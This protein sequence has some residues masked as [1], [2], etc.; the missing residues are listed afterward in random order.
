MD[1]VVAHKTKGWRGSE[2]LWLEK[3]YDMLIGSGVEAVKIMPLAKALG[4]SRTSFYWHF[5]DRD[6]LLAA[7]VRRWEKKNT[8]N[9]VE[10]CERYAE[11]ITEAVFNLFDC[12]I[13]DTL[14]DAKL[15][16][17]IR[18]WAQSAPKLKKRLENTDRD[19]IE[20]IGGMFTRYG[21]SKEQADVRSHTIYYTQVGYISMMV[22]EPM[23]IRIRRM[24]DYIETYTGRQPSQTE[25]ERFIGRHRELLT[26]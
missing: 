17:A 3:A 10:R 2:D 14:F 16:F 13:D 24:P 18:N 8:G 25:I 9:L 7:L 26:S 22:E 20:A 23:D 15:D 1:D 4:L 12:W 11:T 5:E 21:Y 6:A 19:R